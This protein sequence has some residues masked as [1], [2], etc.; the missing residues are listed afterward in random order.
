[1]ARYG[2]GKFG[3]QKYGKGWI[4]W[5]RSY[6]G[7]PLGLAVHGQI[8]W[9]YIYEVVTGNGYYGTVIGQKYQKKFKYKVPSSINNAHGQAS[10]DLFTT[11]NSNWFNVLTD[12]ERKFWNDKATHQGGVYGRNLYVKEYIESNY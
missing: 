6:A 8:G 4:D 5:P 3:Q 10:R 2:Q 1:M 9:E 12:A 7:L 11:A